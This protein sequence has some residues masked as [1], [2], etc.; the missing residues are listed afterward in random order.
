MVSSLLRIVDKSSFMEDRDIGEM[1]HNFDL[2]HSMQRFAGVD[3]GPWDFSE[4]ECPHRWLVW[5]QNLMGFK[6]SLFNSV[7]MFLIAE[8]MIRGDRHDTSNPFQWEAI[9]LNLPGKEG[10]TPTR[11][12]ISDIEEKSRWN[13]GHQLCSFC[14]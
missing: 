4:E 6:P 9:E 7:R 12:W 8:E 10:Y 1:F 11:A 13:A 14:R 3:V 2:H 5:T